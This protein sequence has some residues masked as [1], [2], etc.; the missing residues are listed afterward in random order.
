MLF[1]NRMENQKIH[2]E[3]RLKLSQGMAKFGYIICGTY[4]EYI[5][6]SIEILDAV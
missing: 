5:V 6:G 3:K 4:C 2:P 1:V